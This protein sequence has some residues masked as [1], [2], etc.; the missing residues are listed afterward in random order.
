MFDNMALT[1]LGVVGKVAQNVTALT[2]DSLIE[3]T[4]V[5]RVE[6]V[7]LVENVLASQPVMN[8]VLQSVVN[9]FSAYYMQAVALKVNVGNI[10]IVKLLDPLNP[11]RDVLRNAA[12]FVQG[13]L[14]DF[15]FKLP[16][17]G[18][19]CGL[20][21]YGLEAKI[22]ANIVKY[23][24]NVGNTAKDLA[25]NVL[26]GY[27]DSANVSVSADAKDASINLSVGK[28]LN[29][30]IKQG[31]QS[32][33]IPVSVRLI[34]S[35]VDSDTLVHTL[36]LKENVNNPRSFKER[37]HAWRAGQISFIKDLVMCQDIISE[38]RKNLI[39]DKTGFYKHATGAG[40]K[41]TLSALLSGS[42]SIATASNI[43]VLSESTAKR[44]E[45]DMGGRLR[46]SRSRN[47]LFENNYVMLMVVVDTLREF[48][49]I[50]HRGIDL[51][52]Q[53]TYRDLKA[54]AK[55]SNID[56]GKFL[57]SLMSGQAPS[58]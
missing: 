8:D 52:T 15:Q 2:S 47:K 51:P 49:T 1:A 58:F 24:T 32:A 4:K 42:P 28:L 31:D 57:Q 17:P 20:E 48:V 30:T 12:G 3:F 54:S 6:P 27:G 45:S 53:L 43:M 9:I 36:T 33:T 13:A 19:G 35:L 11:N 25:G 16:V 23:S 41:N 55:D 56:I 22:S 18:M 10:N 50:Y 21:A 5:S 29:V 26:S 7:T 38:H 44:L 46:D 37:Y 39:K 40:N 34:V 14:E